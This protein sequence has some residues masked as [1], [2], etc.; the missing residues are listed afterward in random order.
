MKPFRILQ[1]R[2][3]SPVTVIAGVVVLALLLLFPSAVKSPYAL[4]IMILLFLSII[5]GESWNIVG[6]YTGQYSVGHAAYFGAGA[7][8]TMILMQFRQIPPWYGIL[9]GMAVAVVVALVIGSICFRLR[10]PYFVLASI[11]V[12]EILRLTAMNLKDVTNG[13]E[14]IL[15]T[16]IPP[17][18]FG[19]TV[20]TDFLTKVPFYYVGLTIAV[21]TIVVTWLVQNS[22]LG[23]YIQAIRED[24]DAAHS[25][26]INHAFYKN[27]ALVIS[28]VLTSL[29]GSYYAVYI[30]FIDPP[31]V[32][33]LDISVQIVLICIIG[34][35]GTIWGP[36]IGALVLVPLSEMLRSN[37]VGQ[38]LFNTGL[39]SPESGMGTFLKEHLAHAHAL[40]Y[41]ILVVVVILFMPDGVLGFF[42]K[43]A[44]DK[45]GE[46]R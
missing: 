36:V 5:M 44:R 34:G 14:G 13:A 29:A 35:I 17:L 7:Y 9:A 45:Q 12:A 16:E 37:L 15:T 4:H 28:A 38:V 40:I 30:G 8:T 46:G 3:A 41:G 32:L 31:T 23:Y 42:R 27:V 1:E 10:G 25:L 11:A 22:K 18:K 43:L 24:Q 26:G 33:S 20:I 39:V 6:G 21:I 2:G 19:E